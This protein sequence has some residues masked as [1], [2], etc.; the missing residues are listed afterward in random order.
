M[1]F[2]IQLCQHS[3]D[4]TDLIWPRNNK[5]FSDISMTELICFLTSNE[6]KAKPNN[7]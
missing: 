3:C 2:L 1:G 6:S 7:F 5:S 4:T